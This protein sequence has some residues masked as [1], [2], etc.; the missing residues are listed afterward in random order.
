MAKI[1]KEELLSTLQSFQK[2]KS[3]DLDGLRIEFFLGFY[4]FIGSNLLK[5]VEYSKSNSQTLNAFN[6]TFLVLI[7]KSDNPSK[8]DHCRPISLYNS[9]YKIISKM[10]A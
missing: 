10:I 7:T 3:P 6:S 1:S 5:V 2:D 9:V 8:F 4:D